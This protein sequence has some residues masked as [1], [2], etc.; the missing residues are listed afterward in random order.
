M[1]SSALCMWVHACMWVHERVC[2][3][4]RECTGV[5][6][7][8]SMRL[9]AGI[10]ATSCQRSPPALTWNTHGPY[11]TRTAVD[12]WASRRKVH[13][14]FLCTYACVSVRVCVFVSMCL[15]AALTGLGALD[16][17]LPAASICLKKKPPK[18]TKA[19]SCHYPLQVR[20]HE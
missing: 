1:C 17:R 18:K 6:A 9:C 2:T 15:F 5:F 8:L 19:L 3:R 7:R 11:S 4:V 10:C 20:S 13:I 12:C 16:W 14:L